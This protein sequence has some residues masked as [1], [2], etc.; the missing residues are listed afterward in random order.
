MELLGGK[1]KHFNLAAALLL[2]GLVAVSYWHV[3]IGRQGLRIPFTPLVTALLLIYLARA[4]RHNRRGDFVKVGLILGFGLYMYQAVRMLP[5]VVVVGVLMAMAVR[6]ISWR[7]RQRYLLHLAILVFVSLMVFLPM[8]HYSI[9]FPNQFW[10]R[11]TTRILGDEMAIATPDQAE[12]ALRENVSVFMKN[13][14]N[15]LLMFNWK[16][17]IGWFNGAPEYPMLDIFTGALSDTRRGRLAGVRCSNRAIRSS[18]FFRW[19]F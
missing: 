3:I 7:E 17:D 13:V 9:E 1:R 15:A 12:Q 5:V 4:M 8:L 14:R 16:G 6:R 18:G 19:S 11:T 2:T 10:M